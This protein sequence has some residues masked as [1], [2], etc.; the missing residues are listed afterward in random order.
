MKDIQDAS[1]FAYI[2]YGLQAARNVAK[3]GPAVRGPPHES[4]KPEWDSNTAGCGNDTAEQVTLLPSIEIDSVSF[5]TI[6]GILPTGAAHTGNLTSVRRKQEKLSVLCRH[7]LRHASAS[8]GGVDFV[9]EHVSVRDDGPGESGSITY[10]VLD[11]E[12]THWKIFQG[13]V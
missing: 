7:T 4:L 5:S 6:T 10:L 11:R 13:R 3:P 12:G 1:H 2:S 8:V 9:P